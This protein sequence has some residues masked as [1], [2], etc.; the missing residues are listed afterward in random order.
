MIRRTLLP[1]F[2]ATTAIAGLMTLQPAAANPIGARI[3]VQPW[4]ARNPSRDSVQTIYDNQTAIS[5]T[6]D[7][8]WNAARQ[9]AMTALPQIFKEYDVGDGFRLYDIVVTLNAIPAYTLRQT[10]AN[11]ARLEFTIPATSVETSIRVPGP[12]PNG[13]DPRFKVSGDLV[14]DVE[15]EFSDSSEQVLRAAKVDAVVQNVGLP[16]GENDSASAIESA[17]KISNDVYAFFSGTNYREKLLDSIDGQDLGQQAL[18][19]Q[20]NQGLDVL[21]AQFQR[22]PQLGALF[23]AAVWADHDRLT[24][25]FAPKP[26]SPSTNGSLSGAITWDSA[27]VA[28]DCSQ[29]AMT[30]A[31]QTAPR[32]L[33]DSGGQTYGAPPTAM[34]GA[35][36][37]APAG[38]NACAYSISG[39]APGLPHALNVTTQFAAIGGFASPSPYTGRLRSAPVI[40][41][42]GWDDSNVT[43]NATGRNFT[44]SRGVAAGPSVG[45]LAPETLKRP[46]DPGDER[47]RAGQANMRIQQ[48]VTPGAANSLN[49]QPL[50]PKIGPGPLRPGAANSINPQPL[51]PKVGRVG[52]TDTVASH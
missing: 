52:Q 11:T 49:P 48:Q 36:N 8:A 37:Y 44:I 19:P 38:P 47:Q 39:L 41:P 30:A 13:L 4:D 24:V 28:G 50:P 6:I 15:L 5:G 31:V 45:K 9:A 22:V 33:L 27:Q 51:P 34:L 7:T 35:L 3:Y 10:G 1:L 17:A 46:I 29:V 42:V 20:I 26:I 18:Q 16:Q 32:P 21:N 23:P 14:I 12:T 40:R 43:P 25:Y 2:A